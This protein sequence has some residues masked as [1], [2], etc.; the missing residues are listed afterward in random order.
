MNAE[1]QETLALFNHGLN[2]AQT[3]LS[4]FCEKYGVSKELA[5]RLANGLGSGVRCGETCGAVLGSLLVVGMKYG[6][7]TPDDLETKG[8]CNTKAEEF[9]N[10]F[11]DA[12][13]SII[14]RELLGCDI[15]T[16][17]GLSYAE[18]HDLYRTI[19][20]DK[21]KSAVLLLEELGY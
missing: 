12:N 2:C 6:Q 8:Y 19:C 5:C 4:I 11:R 7:H 14:C 17:E 18:E 15:S 9:I 13:G 10:A 20:L 21:V 1:T 16:K 3:V